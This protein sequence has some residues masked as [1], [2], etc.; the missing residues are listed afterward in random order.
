MT[1]LD[2]HVDFLA[3]LR[4]AGLRVSIAEGLDAADAIRVMPLIDRE[5]LRA[6][7]AAT[8][9][10]RHVDR[11][12]FDTVFDIYFPA[13]VGAMGSGPGGADPQR[14]AP[15]PWEVDDPDRMRL[16]DQLREFL[17]SGDTQAAA[18]IARDAVGSLGT[19][20]GTGRQRPTWSRMT[21]MDRLAPQTLLHELLQQFLAGQDDGGMAET[22]ARATIDARLA[23]FTQLV[24]TDV[25]RRMAAQTSADSL[26]RSAARPSIDRVS[27]LSATR[28]ELAELRREVQPMARRLAARLAYT[29]RRGRRGQIDF[30]RTIRGSLSSG[31]VLLDTRHR[32]RHAV[33]SNLVVL[34]D[35]SSSVSSFAHF[36]L[37][38][39]YALS[40]QFSR[41]R[42]FAF[43]DELDEVTRF[44]TPGGDV[45]EAVERLTAEAKVTWL[46]GRTDYGRAFE[47]FEKRFPDA[48]GTRTSL[49]ILGDARSNY[50]DLDLPTLRRL[51]AKAKHAYW[52]N[53]E[54][55][56]AWDS[57]DS[58]ASR[59]DAVV[60]MVECRN[61]EQ[62]GEFVRSLA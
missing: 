30:R 39:V 54:R 44:F 15:L 22:V 40:E 42:S 50:G 27:F 14:P 58:E 21:V 4:T 18:A 25:Q 48:I 9:V 61:L 57:G 32:P 20:T 8:L 41:V 51:A 52:L 13:V 6:A 45:L 38:L 3:A 31:G 60:P 12:A 36:T 24:D 46:D 47:L 5:A 43:V 35:V 53:P 26:A 2:H 17:L 16:R 11:P 23:R 37:L 33:K 34:C 59:F 62:L 28:T 1:L 56:S 29:Q 10:K 19:L 7:Y 49:L 55:R